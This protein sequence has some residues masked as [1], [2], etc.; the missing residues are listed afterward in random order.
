M[1]EDRPRRSGSYLHCAAANPRGCPGDSLQRGGRATPGELRRA[2]RSATLIAVT[3]AWTIPESSQLIPQSAPGDFYV[4]KDECV[5]CGAPHVVAPDLIGWGT[6]TEYLHCI[7]KKQP[8][9]PEELQQA[10]A[11]FDASDLGCYRYAGSDPAIMNRIGSNY[12]DQGL[13]S[14]DQIEKRPP[15]DET[16]QELHVSLTASK[17][18]LIGSVLKRVSQAFSPFRSGTR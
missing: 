9:T 1:R 16:S 12:C 3:L 10:F 7:W 15:N 18:T 6:G 17:Q 8:E 5:S 2:G 11:A 14:L 13:I 4:V